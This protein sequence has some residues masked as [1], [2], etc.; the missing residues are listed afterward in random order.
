MNGNEQKNE[1]EPKKEMSVRL[2]NV[3]ELGPPSEEA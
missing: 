3:K 2:R 1:C